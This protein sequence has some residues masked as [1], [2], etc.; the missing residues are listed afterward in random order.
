MFIV[1]HKHGLINLGICSCINKVYT[2]K[3]EY[4][5]RLYYPDDSQWD[6]D[7][8]YWDEIMEKLKS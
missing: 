8:Y 3:G 5:C 1:H 2:D 4:V 6:I 7:E